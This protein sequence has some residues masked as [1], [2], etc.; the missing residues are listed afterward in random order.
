[1][2][3]GKSKKLLVKD[4]SHSQSQ[5][6]LGVQSQVHVQDQV[7]SKLKSC[8]RWLCPRQLASSFSILDGK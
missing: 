6:Q 8:G 7:K 1:M 4:Q 5:S 2:A 3:V